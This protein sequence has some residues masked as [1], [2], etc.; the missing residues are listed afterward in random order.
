MTTPFHP[1]EAAPGPDVAQRSRARFVLGI[2]VGVVGCAALAGLA[3]AVDVATRSGPS[4]F[5]ITGQF[6]LTGST[7]SASVPGFACAGTGGYDDL[8][9]ATTVAVTDEAGTLLAKG[10]MTGSTRSSRTCT[11][12]FSVLDV[13][14]G[15]RF[16]QVEIAHR[17]ALSYTETEAESGLSLTLGD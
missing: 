9:P 1:H 15:H 13:P 7:K 12:D 5:A 17:G 4:A 16:Y 6:D 8:N 11:F 10:H 3:F 2:V 14:R